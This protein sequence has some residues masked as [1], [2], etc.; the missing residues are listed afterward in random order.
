MPA[1]TSSWYIG[2]DSG[3][4]KTEL[5]AENSQH[6]EPVQIMGPAAHLQHMSPGETAGVI[7][8]LIRQLLE[9]EREPEIV[10]LCAGIAG[11]GRPEGQEQ[12]AG[13]L[14]E[15]LGTA[16]P[17]ADR[18]QIVHDGVVAL[19]AAFEGESGLITIT[20][21]GSLALA[22]TPG[23][24]LKRAGGWGYLLG[25]NGSGLA[26]GRRGLRAVAAAY[27]G[28]PATRLTEKVAVAHDIRGLDD[29]INTI[30]QPSWPLQE[31][32]PLVLEAAEEGDDMAHTAL[33]K[34]TTLL[35]QQVRWLAGRCG[36][37]KP[38]IAPLGGLA[39]EPLY[40]RAYTRALH[41][42]LPDWSVRKPAHRP[43]VGALRL[44]R[45]LAEQGES[46]SS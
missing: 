6:G 42:E 16:A 36:A 19:E 26:L 29:L 4:S 25:D 11:A 2:I 41:R 31:V 15:A 45:K 12:V 35:A 1:N 10:A 38:Q 14:Q 21:T 18:L 22:R 20:G 13:R 27:D 24:Q 33:R 5:L 7:A 43:A 9:S 30:Y 39:G 23:G 8:G 44:A 40:R 3:G 34:E 37:I 32:A 28:G 46:V 17:P